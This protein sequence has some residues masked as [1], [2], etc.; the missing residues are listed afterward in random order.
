MGS[1]D[2]KMLA[3][4]LLVER[5]GSILGPSALLQSAVF[6]VKSWKKVFVKVSADQPGTLLIEF[7][8]DFVN[9]DFSID[10]RFGYVPGY[11]SPQVL[12]HE[13]PV[14]A[15]YCRIKYTNGLVAQTWF[16][17]EWYVTMY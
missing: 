12:V 9:W 14:Y 8:P 11:A 4:P 3:S 1:I 5:T 13:C 6:S 7:S 16:R 15:R 2:R 10:S 17:L